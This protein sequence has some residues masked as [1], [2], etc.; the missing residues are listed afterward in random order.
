MYTHVLSTYVIYK[1]MIID[2]QVCSV[3]I[4]IYIS[5]HMRMHILMY[6]FVGVDLI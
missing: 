4:Y 6:L 1:C 3:Y 2:E 5:A